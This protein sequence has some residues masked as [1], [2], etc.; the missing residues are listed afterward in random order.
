MDVQ[1]SEYRA[2]MEK[3]FH[4]A[5]FIDHLGIKLT[6]CGPG[7]CEAELAVAPEHLQQNGFVHAGAVTTLADH[8][9]GGAAATLIGEGEYVLTA[10]FKINLLRPATGERLICRAEVLKPGRTL[11]VVE[12]EV[13]AESDGER[14]LVAKMSATIAILAAS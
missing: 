5:P 11:T 14:R 13:H 7:W 3:I 6:D 12:S 4:L 1:N 9:A 2:L 8:C 10:E